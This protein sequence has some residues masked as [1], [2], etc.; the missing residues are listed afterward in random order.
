MEDVTI[1]RGCV[2]TGVGDAVTV[3]V[4]IAVIEEFSFDVAVTVY[5]P[6]VVV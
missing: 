3:M 4:E 2:V 5:V 1:S 6:G